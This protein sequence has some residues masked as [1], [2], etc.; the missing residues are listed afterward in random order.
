MNIVPMVDVI[1][2]NENE[3]ILIKRNREPFKGFYVLPGGHVE[4]ER[5]EETAIREAKEETGLDI[6][7]KEILGVYSGQKRDPRYPTVSTVFIADC[8]GE[9]SSEKEGKPEWFNINKL[10][11]ELGFDHAKIL[12][13]YLKWKNNKETYWS[14][15]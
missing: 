7:L 12:K 1:I 4:N 3:I 6:K 10:P 13:D 5:I 14:S 2:E 9:V 15:K 11:K 8:E